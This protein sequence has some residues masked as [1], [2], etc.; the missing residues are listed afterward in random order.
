[1]AAVEWQVRGSRTSSMPVPSRPVSSQPS[2]RTSMA[3]CA[4]P[5]RRPQLQRQV[6]LRDG[7]RAPETSRLGWGVIRSRARSSCSGCGRRPGLR[8][9][10]GRVRDGDGDTPRGGTRRRARA[11][12]RRNARRR[13]TWPAATR[14]ACAG[15]A[16]PHQAGG[17]DARCRAATPS[18]C[19]SS[20]GCRRP[21][22]R[23]RVR[24]P[25]PLNMSSDSRWSATVAAL[26]GVDDAGP[27]AVADVRGERVDRPLVPVQRDGEPAGSGSQNAS[28]NASLSWSALRVPV[29]GAAPR[30]PPPGRSAARAR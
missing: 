9:A 19:G 7:W 21:S 16:V 3:R 25:Q 24:I 17:D 28:L 6:V 8:R 22:T 27:Q 14:W 18:R 29:A 5:S 15:E 30:R 1:M 10:G 12:G 13:R 4:C 11:G 26:S 23:P 20:S 2:S